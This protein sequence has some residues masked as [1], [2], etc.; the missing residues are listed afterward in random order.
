MIGSVRPRPFE[1]IL[2]RLINTAIEVPVVTRWRQA[3]ELAVLCRDGP[4]RPLPPAVMRT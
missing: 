3:P 1:A 2:A 4:L